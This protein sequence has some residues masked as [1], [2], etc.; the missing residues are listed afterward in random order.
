MRNTLAWGVVAWAVSL[1]VFAACTRGANPTVDFE[2]PRQNDNGFI[3]LGASVIPWAR[4]GATED[5]FKREARSCLNESAASRRSASVEEKAETAYRTFQECM[6]SK[7]WTRAAQGAVVH[8][9]RPHD[10]LGGPDRM[11]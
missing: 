9:I 4:K 1:S 11:D 5:E 8:R 10:T 6:E 3:L 7:Q 2:T